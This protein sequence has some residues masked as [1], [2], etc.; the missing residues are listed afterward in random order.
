[1]GQRMV[2]LDSTYTAYSNTT[3]VL[4]VSQLPPNPAVLAPG[5]AFLFVVVRGVP[6]I[7][8]EVMVGSGAIEPQTVLA[9]ELLPASSM[10]GSDG[11]VTAQRLQSGACS[12]VRD[13]G[14]QAEWLLVFLVLLATWAI[15]I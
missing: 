13:L 10:I 2:V 8:V 14:L 11:A 9:V 1:M 7:G 4:H 12:F 15:H 5:P 3:A 6:S